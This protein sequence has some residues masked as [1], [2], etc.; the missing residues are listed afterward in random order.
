[1]SAPFGARARARRGDR[2][3]IFLAIVLIV[4][5]A[6]VGVLGWAPAAKAQEV[7]T[8]DAASA[9]ADDSGGLQLGRLL[10]LSKRA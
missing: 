6:L 1:V 7:S 5:T 2:A 10:G 8:G 4:F 3:R 9:S